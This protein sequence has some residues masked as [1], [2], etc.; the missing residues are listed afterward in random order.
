MQDP[1]A[2]VT[3]TRCTPAKIEIAKITN[4]Q[5]GGEV[6]HGRCVILKPKEKKYVQVSLTD[7]SGGK[8]EKWERRMRVAIR[9]VPARAVATAKR[10][11][12]N[13]MPK[14]ILQ[15][16]GHQMWSTEK[17]P[18]PSYFYQGFGFRCRLGVLQTMPR[19]HG[20]GREI[21]HSLYFTL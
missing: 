15:G 11:V 12:M 2:V 9:T 21:N 17:G 5:E 6:W 13:R 14:Q 7:I 16:P 20:S 8:I 4:L 19:L 10:P 3:A 18:V 1:A